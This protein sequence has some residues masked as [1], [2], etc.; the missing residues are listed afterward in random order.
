VNRGADS[1][2]GTATTVV[3][4]HRRIDVCIGGL[5]VGREKRCRTHDLTGLAVAALGG[6]A[7]Y[8]CALQGMQ[9]AG[10]GAAI[11]AACPL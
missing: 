10:L 5:N 1:N 6:I 9:I 11:T 3:S 2:V 7:V 8:P 4:C